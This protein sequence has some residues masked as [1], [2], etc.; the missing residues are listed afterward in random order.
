MDKTG[1][2]NVQQKCPKVMSPIGAK[3]IGATTLQEKGTLVTMV[4]TLDA[5]EISIPMYLIFGKTH[6]M[7]RLLDGAPPGTRLLLVKKKESID[8]NR[9]ISWL[10]WSLQKVCA[11]LL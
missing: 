9:T 1:L 5:M 8:D 10:L 6:F 3:R 11:V 4:G 7:V 2:K